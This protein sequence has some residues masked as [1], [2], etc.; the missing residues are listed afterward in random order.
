MSMS[1][2]IDRIQSE[3]IISGDEFTLDA[4]FSMDQYSASLSLF[5]SNI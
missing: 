5:N 2:D 3:Q 4:L 1:P